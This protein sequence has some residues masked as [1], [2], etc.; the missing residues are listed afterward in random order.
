MTSSNNYVIIR[1]LKREKLQNNESYRKEVVIIM[2]YC[3]SCGAP[4]TDGANFCPNCGMS[5]NGSTGGN[6]SSDAARTATTIAGTVIGASLLSSLFHRRRRHMMPP[7]HIHYHH[8]GP[9]GGFGG[10]GHGPGHGG[11]GPH[12]GGFG[13]R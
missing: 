4:F 9:M 12:G 6:R 10:L 3:S 13:H 2:S 7:P 11:R 1:Q 5:A 8:R